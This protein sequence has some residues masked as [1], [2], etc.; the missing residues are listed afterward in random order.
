MK[1]TH[2]EFEGKTECLVE[3]NDG[4]V[5]QN[6]FS[7]TTGTSTLKLHLKEKHSISKK[8]TQDSSAKRQKMINGWIARNEEEFTKTEEFC[9]TWA[10]CGLSYSLV[11]NK[12]FRKTFSASYP[13]NMNR[14]SISESMMKLAE[15]FDRAVKDKIR[16]CACT[17]CFGGW[18]KRR[19]PTPAPKASRKSRLV[20]VDL[21]E[22]EEMVTKK[23]RECNRFT[24][25]EE[26]VSN[27]QVE[28]QELRE[29]TSQQ[30]A[31][32]EEMETRIDDLDENIEKLQ[33]LINDQSTSLRDLAWEVGHLEERLERERESDYFS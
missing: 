30:T 12:R 1:R 24:S 27:Q 17:L 32:I 4:K 5:C 11:D 19:L 8:D 18:T 26:K 31:I 15:Q 3:S 14:K 23:V 21:D 10:T 6:T 20:E 2:S 13:A 28:I 29:K 25:L 7:S 33:E 22:F 16:G 9:I